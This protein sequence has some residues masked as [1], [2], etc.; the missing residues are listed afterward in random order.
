MQ[1]VIEY[2]DLFNSALHIDA[3]YKGGDNK[4]TSDDPINKLM[5]CGNQGGFRYLGNASDLRKCKLIVL[6]TSGEDIDW[7]DHIDIESGSFSYYGDNKKPGHLL[8]DT[9]RKGNL[10][11]KNVFD[12][13]HSNQLKLIPPIFIFSK[14]PEGRDVI[15]KGLCVPGFH[16][17]S[18]T[19]DLVA[20][21]KIKESARFQNYKAIFSILDIPLISQKWI[22]DIMKGNTFKSLDCPP[23]FFN[24]VNTNKAKV[25]TAQR[26]IEYRTKAEQIPLGKNAK[27]LKIIFDYYR[28][29]PHGF[30]KCAAEIALLMDKN[31]VSYDLTR[32][33]Q[34]GGRDA[35]GKYKIGNETTSIK[36]DFALEAK[37][38]SYMNAVGV[39][40][41]SRLIS[42]LRYRQF[43]LLITTSYVHV[44]AY[45][46]IVA[47]KH[48]VIVI[49]AKDIISILKRVG[50]KTSTEVVKWLDSI[51]IS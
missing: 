27:L 39:K 38:Y 18:Q 49:S 5:K 9:P 30:E 21:W 23:E 15:F 16:G 11:L 14:G 7:P 25:L 34:D 35:I 4:N 10:L 45:K 29:N 43:G 42:R 3:I 47:D 36:V 37:C 1:K 6:Y 19:E 26:T 8:H 13:L 31:F 32:P 22:A 20:I 24:W 51:E 28:N 44:Q 2:G 40:E 12:A 41:T 17:Y 50:I 33:W 48:P 46:E